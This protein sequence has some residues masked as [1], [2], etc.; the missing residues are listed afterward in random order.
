MTGL[1]YEYECDCEENS[2]IFTDQET[3]PLLDSQDP[4]KDYPY[5]RYVTRTVSAKRAKKQSVNRAILRQ[6]L[7]VDWAESSYGTITA[8]PR[9]GEKRKMRDEGLGRGKRIRME[10]SS[11]EDSEW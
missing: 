3:R 10:E 9:V 5:G 8:A 7:E 6:M 1:H 4:L 11:E 2:P